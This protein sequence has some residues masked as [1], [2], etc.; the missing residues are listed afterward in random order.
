MSA[1]RTIC[2]CVILARGLG[3]RIRSEDRVTQLDAAQS[4][5]AS[6]GLKAMIP[7]GRPFLDFELSAL[8]DAG[9][10]QVCLVIGPEHDVVR[11]HY[12]RANR[13]TRIQISLAEQPEARGTAD[14]L[15]A[16]EAFAG[17]DEF[18][19]LNGDNFYPVAALQEIQNLG[20]PGTVLFEASTLV[21]QS[22]IPEERIRA[23]AYCVVDQDGFLADIVEKPEA[24]AAANF[25]G[26]KLVSM[27][28][29]RFGPDIFRFCREVPLSPRVE[30]EL[31]IAVKLAIK[32]GTKLKAAISRSGVL[33]LSRR[34]DIAAVTE[35]LRNVKVQL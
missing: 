6:A 25:R 30:Y 26:E 2:K 3:T 27:N 1:S 14:A 9:F 20:Q 8:A 29:W 34:S 12:G 33:D 13:P 15:L 21:S 31:P 19:V 35:R 32:H 4:A 5:A 28:C 11:E 7:V 18:A 24:T 23:F 17:S 22:N 10:H 16:G